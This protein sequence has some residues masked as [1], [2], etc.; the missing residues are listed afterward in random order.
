VHAF[1]RT[2]RRVGDLYLLALPVGDGRERYCV[3]A[4]E[5]PLAVF[6]AVGPAA[7]FFEALCAAGAPPHP[8][9]GGPGGVTDLAA[10]RAAR[11]YSGPPGAPGPV[12]AASPEPVSPTARRPRPGRSP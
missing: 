12:A 3:A 7:A 10:Y 8:T 4:G 9:R 11:A 1:G 5:T 2:L 6:A